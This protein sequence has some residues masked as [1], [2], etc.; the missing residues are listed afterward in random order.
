[1]FLYTSTYRCAEHG[2]TCY[3]HTRTG[4]THHRTFHVFTEYG[5]TTCSAVYIVLFRSHTIT[6]SRRPHD[7]A[8]PSNPNPTALTTKAGRR[9]GAPKNGLDRVTDGRSKDSTMKPTVERGGGSQARLFF[10]C[11][12]TVS[13]G[14]LALP[15]AASPLSTPSV[16]GLAREKVWQL[17][18][19]SK[20]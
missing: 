4:D 3:A 9:T 15:I 20:G 6:L 16:R 7:L 2:I 1:M 13:R 11:F 14:A 5:R 18:T 17:A 19:F 8:L 12:C 10:L